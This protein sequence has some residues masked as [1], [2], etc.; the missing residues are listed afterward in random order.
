MW[1]D[2]AVNLS[3]KNSD[4]PL[5]VKLGVEFAWDRHRFDVVQDPNLDRYQNKNLDP[6]RHQNDAEP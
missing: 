6:D 5:C 3:F 1:T 4:F 2:T